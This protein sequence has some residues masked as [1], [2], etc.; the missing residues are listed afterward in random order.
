M[1]RFNYFSDPVYFFDLSDLNNITYKET[2]NID[3][4]STSL[5][6][7]GNGY[8]LGI[9]Q[10]DW[11]TFKVEIYKE[12]ETGVE[13]FCKYIQMRV[14]YS[15]DYK[16]YYI[17]RENQLIGLGLTCNTGSGGEKYV[18][19]HFDGY[20]LVELVKTELPGDNAFISTAIYTCLVRTPSRWWMSTTAKQRHLPEQLRPFMT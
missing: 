18:L 7:M 2:G 1:I 9:G 6:N 4:F 20:N 3:G 14:D 15:T 12:T 13:G 16:S 10:E 17:D 8:L 5:I 19:L 11:N